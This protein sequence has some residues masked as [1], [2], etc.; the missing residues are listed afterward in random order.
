MESARIS[1]I[2]LV[3]NQKGSQIFTMRLPPECYQMQ[4]TIQHYLPHLRRSQL[5][6]L[7]LWVY[8]TI[9]SG[10][11]CQNA[12]LTALSLFGNWHSLR[13]YLREWLYDG[14]DR[15]SPCAV[16]LDVRV[17]FVPLLSWLL[18]WWQSDKLA[19]A[20][21]PTMKGDKIAAIVI[22]VVYRSCAIPIAWHMLPANTRG[23]WMVPMVELLELLAPA[24]PKHMQVIVLCDR[25]L[26][27]PR[28]YRQICAVGWHPYVRQSINTVFCPD[29]GGRI[30]AR[31][32]VPAPG[33]AWVG[34]GTA[35]RRSRIRRRGTLIVVWERGQDAPW[36]VMTDLAPE[37]AGVCWYALRF[38]IE[39]GFRAIKGVG[40]QWQHSRRTDPERVSR[41]WLVLSVATLLTLAY[42]SR[43]E[44]AA[45]RCVAPGRLRAPPKSLR[46]AQRSAANRPR[47]LVSVLR[48]GMIC[49]RRLLHKGRMWRRVWLLP[50][51][52]PQPT[53]NLKVVYHPDT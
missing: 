38:W 14:R 34:S 37:D 10:S 44:D 6:G 27:S 19:L 52:W 12:V 50:E 21:D 23:Q 30:H 41:H 33:H 25:G 53:A 35:F 8:G 13:Q 49:L 46:A 22:S 45:V 20:I 47:R 39:L 28:L 31:R 11:S 42:G 51:E 40:W 2:L 1:G 15:A 17:C 9:T 4:Q 3:T 29:G 43:V 26:R 48:L 24:V 36:I 18:D 5:S 16:Q 32:L 7:T